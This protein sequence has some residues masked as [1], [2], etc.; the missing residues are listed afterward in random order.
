M[1][2][3]QQLMLIINPISGTA[4]KAGLDRK[5]VHRFEP[6][7][8]DIDVRF[9]ERAGHATELATEAVARQYAGVIAAGGDG[10]INE[11]ARALCNTGVPLGII[12]AGSGNGLARHVCIPIDINLALDVISH[13]HAI[14]IDYGTVNGDPFFCTMGVGFDASVSHRFASQGK[15]GMMMYVKSML[16][17]YRHYENETYTI[18]ANG[19]ILTE[20]AFVI[21]VANASQYGNNAYIAPHASIRDGLLDVTIIHNNSALDSARISF[22]M[23]T[24]TLDRN[25]RIITF[26]TPSVIIYRS[27][28]GPAHMDGEPLI[29]GDVLDVRCHHNGLRLFVPP[30]KKPFTPYLT[31]AKATISDFGLKIKHI[32]K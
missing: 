24:G 4:R 9:T 8:Y 19:H 20:K 13:L 31:P 3:K 2:D 6:L 22:D 21:A 10:T 17:V 16:E 28:P 11:V 18:S 5:V 1:S 27:A 12:P 23:M 30:A 25:T 15:R 32:F 7:G 26:R 29:L 14:D